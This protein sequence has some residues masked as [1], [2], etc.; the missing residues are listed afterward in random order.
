M[1]QPWISRWF[2]ELELFHSDQERREAQAHIIFVNLRASWWTIVL[3]GLFILGWEG[4]TR[5][6]QWAALNR[7]LGTAAI[8]F[9]FQFATMVGGLFILAWLRLGKIRRLL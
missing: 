8:V 9:P 1:R 3:F 6:S 4:G 7:I 2:P 5:L